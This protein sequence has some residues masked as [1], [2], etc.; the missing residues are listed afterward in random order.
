MLPPVV[1]LPRHPPRAWAPQ[2][3]A[4]LEP[5]CI[6]VPE[7]PECL[8]VVHCMFF[9]SFSSFLQPALYFKH[10]IVTHEKLQLVFTL[11]L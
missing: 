7:R 9:S 10:S 8:H 1:R 11:A 4:R 3:G 6:M 5:P 2:L